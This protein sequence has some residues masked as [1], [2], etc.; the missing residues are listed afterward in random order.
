MRINAALVQ[1]P[2][3]LESNFSGIIDIINEE[4][5][6]FEGNN[7]LTVRKEGIPDE[8]KAQVAEYRKHVAEAYLADRTPTPQEI[9]PLLDNVV[10]Y[11]PDPS[12]IK[13]TAIRVRLQVD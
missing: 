2:I 3:G 10:K 7:G 1:L 8:Y 13:H 12:E 4:S 9:D 11:L 6:Y 5:L